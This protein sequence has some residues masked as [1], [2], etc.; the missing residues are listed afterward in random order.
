MTRR[1]F[2]KGAAACGLFAGCAT[3]SGRFVAQGEIRAYLMHLGWNM[4][5]DQPVKKWGAY[6]PD[7]VNVVTAADSLRTDVGVWNR[8]TEQMAKD[9]YNMVIVDLG[10]ALVYPSHPELSARGAWSPERMRD[11]IRRLRAL[12]LEPIPKMNFSTAHDTWLG[13]YGRMVSTGKYYEVCS[14]LI[15]D[16]AGIFDRPRFL[17][18]GYDEE[19]ADHQKRYSLCIVRQGD[20][21]WHDFL[22][23]AKETE[24]TGMRPW[25]WSDFVTH[26]KAEFLSKM[27]KSVL[28]SN[29]YYGN[30]FKLGQPVAKPRECNMVDAYVELEKAGFDQI[31]TGSNWSCDENL[32]ETVRFCRAHIAPSRLKGFMM[33]P[34]F[35]P[36]PR[37]EKKLTDAC[38]LGREA[39]RP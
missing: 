14:D 10:E 5:A 18:L 15:R 39:F 36:D 13:P 25:I 24:K 6:K 20:L 19:T 37:W 12:G 38:R 34:W 29:W 9:G 28:Q 2:V 7:E 11:E 17:H 31:P 16:V 33:A 4:W 35:F 32:R 1:E 23:F 26:H 8:V 21:W 30:T 3:S 22:W 27:P